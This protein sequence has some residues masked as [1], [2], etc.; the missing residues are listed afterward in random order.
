M[1]TVII[2]LKL[3]PDMVETG[4]DVI[5]VDAGTL[6]LLD[7]NIRV[8]YAIGDFDS[9]SGKEL[10]RIVGSVDNVIRLNPIKDDSDSE[11]ALKLAWELGYDQAIIYGG[12]GG[13][14]DHEIVNLRL[15]YQNPNRVKLIDER[16]EIVS[17]KEGTYKIQKRDFPFISFFTQE[18]AEISLIGMKYPLEHRTINCRD[19]YTVS[20][21]IVDEEG[22]LI[23]HS[24]VILTIQSK[25]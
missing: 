3:S 18:E 14:I 12:L 7:A 8:K 25:D 6:K 5:G 10:T 9:V 2:A 15:V 17:Y 11:S 24:G 23:V 13:R 22:T 16:N 4:Y 1:A 19:L 20:N 21:E